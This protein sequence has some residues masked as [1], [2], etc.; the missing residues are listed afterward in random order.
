MVPSNLKKSIVARDEATTVPPELQET[1]SSLSSVSSYVS[2]TSVSSP[3]SIS[4][5][6]TQDT[7]NPP[8]SPS[9]R[10]EG[11]VSSHA[12]VKREPNSDYLH[13]MWTVPMATITT[14][15]AS[16]RINDISSTIHEPPV[17]PTFIAA[18]AAPPP[19][20]LPVPTLKTPSTRP[21]TTRLKRPRPQT[22]PSSP[23]LSSPVFPTPSVE[24]PH[25]QKV[26]VRSSGFK[27]MFRNLIGR[28]N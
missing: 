18:T 14:T 11:I 25:A 2:F 28:G 15:S 8:C 20:S 6:P 16:S 23:S 1:S 13:P 9:S 5:P 17:Q 10:P 19:A 4:I 7:K 22:A 26:G 24:S 3:G 27:S 21:N 12:S